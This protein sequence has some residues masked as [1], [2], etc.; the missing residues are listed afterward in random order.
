MLVF[1][2]LAYHGREVAL[3][4]LGLFEHCICQ[5]IAAQ[6]GKLSQ[7][8]ADRILE[9]VVN[10]PSTL[11]TAEV[12]FRRTLVRFFILF[13]GKVVHACDL[14]TNELI[15]F[16]ALKTQLLEFLFFQ[17]VNKLSLM[18]QDRQV[19]CDVI[20]EPI[21]L[22][23]EIHQHRCEDAVATIHL[24]SMDNIAHLISGWK[25]LHGWAVELKFKRFRCF[26]GEVTEYRRS[27]LG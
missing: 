27:L 22:L 18:A 24:P 4:E 15:Q 26:V 5:L 2:A 16:A 11:L 21:A 25:E 20:L 9:V 19:L 23:I 14:V 7:R 6:D 12:I 1:R 10:I 17:R 8:E 13:A 3:A